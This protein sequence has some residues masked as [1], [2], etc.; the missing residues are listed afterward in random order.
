MPD[1]GFITYK[2]ARCGSKGFARTETSAI[3]I[4]KPRRSASPDND[5]AQIDEHRRLLRATHIW[6]ESVPIIHTPGE[7]YLAKRGIVL[8]DVPEHGLRWHPAC[9][10]EAGVASC[11]VS[12]FTDAVTSAPKGIHRRPITGE[13]PKMLGLMAG[14]VI[15]LWPDEDVAEGLVIGE[16]VETTLAV[17]TRITHRGTLLRPAWAAGSADNLARFP[18]LAGIEA[19]TILVDNDQSGA[20]QRAA[21]KCAQRWRDAGREVIRLMPGHVGLDFNDLVKP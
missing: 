6:F 11:I 14:C 13:K 1:D 3:R 12:R 8:D 10:W 15:R 7:A 5:E 21:S 19:L 20:G 18:V 4:N 9:P 16:G 17:A 2:C